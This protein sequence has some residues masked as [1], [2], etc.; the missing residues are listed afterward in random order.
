MG[1][2]GGMIRQTADPCFSRPLPGIFMQPR[3]ACLAFTAVL[4]CSAVAVGG[5]SL[6]PKLVLDLW[7]AAYIQGGRAGYVHTSVHEINKEGTKILR[8]TTEL[9]LTVK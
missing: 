7:D 4:A 8:A 2:A 1:K 3:A 5:S 9:R 6:Q